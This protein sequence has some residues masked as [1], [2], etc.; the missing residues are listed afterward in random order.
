VVALRHRTLLRN[1]L[2]GVVL[3]GLIYLLAS[4][5][6]PTML[7][8]AAA[9]SV[10]VLDA[11]YRLVRRRPVSAVGLAFVAL[12][13]L[14][15]ALAMWLHSPMFILAKGAVVSALVGTA[16]ALSALIRKPLTRTLALHLSTDHS[17][18]RRL[19]AERWRHPRAIR[20]FCTLSAAW[21]VWLLITAG[22]QLTLALTLRPGMVMAL[23]P[24]VH[25]A[26][27]AIG[28]VASVIYVRRHQRAH[29]EL[30]ILPVRAV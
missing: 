5:V 27:L 6:A 23:D 4:R 7:A 25:A 17:E 22:Q 29:P 14:S 13:G 19:L 12:T 1:V 16:F 26:A 18:D 2:P 21:G 28:T 30:A 15:V 3:P 9:S 24:P 11:G 10:P 20:V 8:L